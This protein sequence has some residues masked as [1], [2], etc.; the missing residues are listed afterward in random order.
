M[1]FGRSV[2]DEQLRRQARSGSYVCKVTFHG[3]RPNADE[4]S[5]HHARTRRRQR[6]RQGRP[7]GA[8]SPA[9]RV[10]RAGTRPSCQPPDRGQPPHRGPRWACRRLLSRVQLLSGAPRTLVLF[11]RVSPN[12][13]RLRRGPSA[14]RGKAPSS[15]SEA[16][17]RFRTESQG[18]TVVARADAAGTQPTT[19]RRSSAGSLGPGLPDRRRR[20]RPPSRR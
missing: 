6:R 13:T 7:T 10:H 5:P 14:E 18:R 12:P 1:T 19:R 3:A 15:R 16:R 20:R 4:V 17:R 8:V 11:M 9:A 2:V